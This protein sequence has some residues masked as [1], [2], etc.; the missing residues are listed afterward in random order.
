MQ[1]HANNDDK[2]YIQIKLLLNFPKIK[3][4]LN[5]ETKL[6]LYLTND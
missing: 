6:W 4:I 3:K 1:L 2:K 5:D